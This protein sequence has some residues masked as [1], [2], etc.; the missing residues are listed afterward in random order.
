M[1][2]DK[3]SIKND[4]TNLKNEIY[5]KLKEYEGEIKPVIR[6]IKSITFDYYSFIEDIKD[7]QTCDYFKKKIVCPYKDCY[8][9]HDEYEKSQYILKELLNIKLDNKSLNNL[10]KYIESEILDLDNKIKELNNKKYLY[11]SLL[12]LMKSSNKYSSKK[13]LSDII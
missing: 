9:R 4:I 6:R 12:I 3:K 8:F 1:N 13:L 5:L 11:S 2:L 7:I 10:F